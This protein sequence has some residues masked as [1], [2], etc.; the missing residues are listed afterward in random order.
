M[1][2]IELFSE[3]LRDLSALY[4]VLSHPARLAIL[5]YLADTKT[6]ISGDI[7][8]EL[9]LSRTTVQQHLA[10]LNKTG[11]IKGEIKGVRNNY[12]LNP[13]NIRRIKQQM[14]QFLEELSDTNNE[15]C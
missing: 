2:K 5:K 7:S 9:P 11:F 12:C 8:G 10:E 13:E 1:T 14:D 3:D 6:C 4:K 15:I